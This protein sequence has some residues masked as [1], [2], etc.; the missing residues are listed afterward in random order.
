MIKNKRPTLL[1][2][3]TAG[4]VL[5][6]G[7]GTSQAE[8]TFEWA[9]V[10]NPGNIADTEVMNDGTSGYGAVDYVYRISKH[11]VTHTQYAE[12]LNAVDPTGANSLGLYHSNIGVSGIFLTPS[13]PNGSKYVA[14]SQ[15]SNQPVGAVTFYNTLRFANWLHNGQG[16]GDTETGAYTLLGGTPVPSNANS[17]TRNTGAKVFLTSEDEWYKAAYYDPSTNSYFDY[18][19]SSN[20]LPTAEPPP[21]GS[22]SANYDGAGGRTPVGS[23]TNSVSPFGTFDQ[24]GNAWEWNESLIDGTLRNFRGGSWGNSAEILPASYRITGTTPPTARGVGIGFRVASQVPEP[25]TLTIMSL[26]SLAL[27][28]RRKR[29]A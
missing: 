2:A 23:Y 21:G 10:G 1:C 27:M 3:L 12:F 14:W 25:A 22:N 7:T 24:S 5:T 18:A 13:N 16:N 19:T 9:T 4:A 8:V 6:F 11:E 26:G 20:T 15:R 28:R 29:K 17:V